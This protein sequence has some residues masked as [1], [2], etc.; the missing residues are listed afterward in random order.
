VLSNYFDIRRITTSDDD[1]VTLVNNTRGVNSVAIDQKEDMLYWADQ[2]NK[3]ISRAPM[4]RPNEV[5]VIQ[6]GASIEKPEALALDWIGRKMYW[7]D[8]GKNHIGV[9]ELD[10]SSSSIL[11][12]G[13]TGE[14]IRY[15]TVYPEK[16]L[17]FWTDWGNS[18]KSSK[19][20][21]ANLDGSDKRTI[22][23]SADVEWPNG[24]RVDSVIERLFWVDMA[25]SELCSSKIDGSDIKRLATGLES[26]FDLTVFE[27]YVYWTN[28]KGHKL[29]K[30]N[31]FTGEQQV[32][33]NRDL[34]F[35]LG[36]DVYHPIRQRK[37]GTHPCEENNGG[38]SHLCLLSSSKK[39]HSCRCPTGISLL[40]DG[41]KCDISIPIITTVLEQCSSDQY[42][43]HLSNKC[44]SRSL[45][46]D[47]T[48]VR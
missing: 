44:I 16:G 11:V 38:C 8:L 28:N 30:A 43:R 40:P 4:S 3:S 31:K 32:E 2:V 26:P 10:G 9:S 45:M 12:K 21:S 48:L 17:I 41:K 29:H 37:A 24:L 20:V 6:S 36:L 35:P 7:T 39:Q 27:D 42:S 46:C 1:F 23:T 13:E 34:F 14:Q 25:R 47:Q 33:F 19:I 18:G 22:V 15:I 5:S